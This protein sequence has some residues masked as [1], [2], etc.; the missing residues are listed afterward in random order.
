[1]Q[2]VLE[3][4]GMVPSATRTYDVGRL[5]RALTSAWGVQPVVKCTCPGGPASECEEALLE[6]ARSRS[7]APRSACMS[8]AALMPYLSALCLLALM[9]I[10]KMFIMSEPC[11]ERL[12]LSTFHAFGGCALWCMASQPLVRSLP[13]GRRNQA[14]L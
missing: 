3:D 8:L 7:R 10:L 9:F 12:K 6:S 2:T 4:A 13:V 1:M 11:L 14:L 5:Q